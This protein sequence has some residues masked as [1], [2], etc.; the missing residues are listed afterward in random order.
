MIDPLINPNIDTE[1]QEAMQE[2]I[3]SEAI[4]YNGPCEHNYVHLIS[5]I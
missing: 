2:W 4:G 1:K 3:D 5:N